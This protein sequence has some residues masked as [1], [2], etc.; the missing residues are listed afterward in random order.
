MLYAFFWV[1]PR[2]LNFVCRR[3]GTLCA[4]FIGRWLTQ[5]RKH[6]T[7][8]F[9]YVQKLL[10]KIVPL[11]R[12]CGRVPYSRIGHR[13]RAC[14][15]HAGYDI[16]DT[17]YDMIYL[18]TAIGLTPGGRSTIHIYTQTIHRTTQI[19]S[20]LEECG[21]CPIFASFTPVFALQLRKKHGKTSVRAA[22][23]W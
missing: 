13:W 8:H 17:W 16:Y 2:R 15:L 19:T 6:T 20:N 7:K 23:E 10:P 1:I 14:A 21:P 9:L 22:E 12:L 5:K 18:S 4:I 11:T 3:F